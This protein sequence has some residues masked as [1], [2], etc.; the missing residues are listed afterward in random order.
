[1]TSATYSSRCV[2]TASKCTVLMDNWANLKRKLRNDKMYKCFLFHIKT[3]WQGFVSH[4]TCG[5]DTC[6]LLI[7]DV[8]QPVNK[9]DYMKTQQQVLCMHGR[10]STMEEFN[11]C[12]CTC[13][14]GGLDLTRLLLVP[15]SNT[16]FHV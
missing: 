16:Q 7:T 6:F 1:M 8:I 13:N 4:G 3:Q 2:Q 10:F 11:T 14:H 12:N 15:G 5:I 9:P